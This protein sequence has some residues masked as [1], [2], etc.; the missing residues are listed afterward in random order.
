MNSNRFLLIAIKSIMIVIAVL[1]VLS[2]LTPFLVINRL[3]PAVLFSIS[4]PIVF[5]SC[6]LVALLSIFFFKKQW[7][8]FFVVILIGIK[9]IRSS[10]G[11]NLQQT[12]LTKK[13][14]NQY[15]R[16]LSWN[17]S[18]FIDNIKT[19]DNAKKKKRQAMLQF[20]KEVNAD[21]IC[22]QDFRD[23]QEDALYNS[24]KSI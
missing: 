24:N 14:S 17:V 3:N 15:V 5:L 10:I 1:Y 22:S 9:N 21:V 19:A 6:C 2:S 4:F 13:N 18:E 20:I 23:F 11:F 8:I 7:W 16:T 12:R